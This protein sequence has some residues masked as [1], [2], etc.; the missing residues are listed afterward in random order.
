MISGILRHGMPLPYTIDLVTSLNLGADA[1]NTWKAGVA[2][3]IKKYIKD[4]TSA[5]DT[6]CPD[7]G[8]EKGLVYEEGCLKCKSCGASKC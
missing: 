1:L 8:D 5:K 6:K 3:M 4:G 2:R 7:C